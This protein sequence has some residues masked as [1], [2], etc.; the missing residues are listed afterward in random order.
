MLFD[1]ALAIQL[2]SANTAS[3]QAISLNA[4]NCGFAGE[5]IH[6]FLGGISSS[7]YRQ[8][9]RDMFG[10]SAAAAGVVHSLRG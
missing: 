7:R 3:A 1:C 9:I 10:I 8:Q 5:N 4:P 6:P 2:G